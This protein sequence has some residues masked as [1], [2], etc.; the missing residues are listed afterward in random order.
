MLYHMGCDEKLQ[1]K[2]YNELMIA[3]DN[4]TNDLSR[5]K[6]VIKEV[7]RFDAVATWSAR[8]DPDNDIKLK[9]TDDNGNRNGDSEREVIIPKGTPIIESLGNMLQTHGIWPTAHVFDPTWFLTDNTNTNKQLSKAQKQAFQPFGGTGKR[10]CPGYNLFYKESL[11]FLKLF[12]KKFR[13]ELVD[14]NDK[15]KVKRVY[16]LV[17]SMSK[18][19]KMRLTLR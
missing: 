15:R 5:C 12:L 3:C 13:V 17:S 6:A 11:L 14:Q 10:I 9:I 8:V 4:K 2:M 7:L 18:P 19:V 16:G 1:E